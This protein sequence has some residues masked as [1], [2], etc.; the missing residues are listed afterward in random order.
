MGRAKQEKE[1]QDAHA[2]ACLDHG[3]KYKGFRQAALER[4]DFFC[5][6]LTSASMPARRSPSR[7]PA[8]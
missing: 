3:A 2:T 4:R 8:A 7:R 6:G 1:G 5:A